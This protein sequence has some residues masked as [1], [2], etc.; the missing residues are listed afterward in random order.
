MM[1]FASAIAEKTLDSL[2]SDYPIVRDFFYNLNIR[3]LNTSLTL[4]EALQDTSDEWL[5]EFGLTRREIPGQLASFLDTMNSSEAERRISSLTIIGGVDK[6]G[7]P[8]DIELRIDAGT[9]VSV[10]G[11]TGSGKS[12][13]LGDIECLAQG[14]TPT[15][16]AILIDGSPVADDDRF[17]LG[18]K[19]VAQLSQNMNFVMD[20]TVAEFLEMHA[21][22]RAVG[23]GAGGGPNGLVKTCFDRANCLSGE[24]FTLDDK[25]TSLSGGQSRALMIADCAYMSRSAIV[26]IDEI[27][28]AGVDRANAVALLTRAEKIVLISTHDPLLAL[29][30]DKRVVIK[31][32]GIRSV[33][34][35][36]G[37]ERDILREISKIDGLLNNAREALRSGARVT[38]GNL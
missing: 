17:R 34:E 11:P 29:S 7:I 32:G 15:R 30:A 23:P 14:D 3:P 21:H 28:N 2:M 6:D 16:R 26:L 25:V 18:G 38:L 36:S 19:L 27:E 4:S 9:V 1:D 12:R 37:E 5:E 24:K 13:L 20:L 35:T 8:E 10:V 22:S 31:N 33:L